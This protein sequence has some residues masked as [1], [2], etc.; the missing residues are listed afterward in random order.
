[1]AGW[2][3]GWLVDRPKYQFVFALFYGVSLFV[4]PSSEVFSTFW[5]PSSEVF[6]AFSRHI[7]KGSPLVL[8]SLGVFSW[9]LGGAGRTRTTSMPK[10]VFGTTL[11]KQGGLSW[12][13]CKTFAELPRAVR[14]LKCDRRLAPGM[15]RGPLPWVA[16]AAMM[17]TA[18]VARDEKF[19][20]LLAVQ[21]V[22]YLRPSELWSSTTGQAIYL[23][24]SGIGHTQL[25]SPLGSPGRLKA[26]QIAQFH[27]SISLD[28]KLSVALGKVLARCTAC[29]ASS[30][31][32]WSRS[33]PKYA[34]DFARWAEAT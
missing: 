30:T 6:S 16:A 25:S 11:R 10:F 13:G 21:Y 32:L 2:L 23:A 27:E 9:R 15:S 5:P 26:S 34:Q 14:V 1:M 20:V 19:A 17:G 24:S 8:P 31:P 4:W 29:K 33:Q 28:G 3:V 18:M 7:V 12:A 22:A